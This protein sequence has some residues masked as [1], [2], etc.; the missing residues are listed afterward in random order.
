MGPNQ[1]QREE[2]KRRIIVGFN[3]RGRDV[4][5]V[6][7]EIQQK[8][9]QQIKFP[10]GY[11]PT[12]GGQF[13]N[14]QEANA[15]LSIAIPAALALIFILL[16]LT[17]QSVKQSLV[18]FTAIPMAAIGGVFSLL[19]RGMPFSISAGIGFI[20]L[21]GVAV[22]NG[23]VL[24]AEFNRLK[25]AGLTDLYDIVRKG[26]HIRLR[27]VLMTAA[28]ASLGFMPMALATS[29][30]A[31]VQKPLAT[32]VIGGLISSTLLTLIVIP[33][34]Y[35]YSEKI[36]LR[37]IKP[38]SMVLV[39]FFLLLG[40]SS[41]QA[42]EQ[43]QVV[44]LQ[45]AIEIALKNNEGIKAVTYEVES[46]KQLKKT[47]L[48]LPKTDITFMRGQY[49]SYYKNDNNITVM[50]SIPFTSLGSNGVLNR[51]LVESSELKKASTENE[52]IYQVKQT[53]YQ[54]AYANARHELLLQ[55]DSIYEGFFKAASLRYKAGETN[56]LEQ[57]T[58]EAQRN[59]IKNQI[60]QNEATQFIL[61]TQLKMLM[62]S[63]VL[64]EI[65]EE[66][67]K[68][69]DLSNSLDTTAL[70]SNPSLA[71]MRQQVEVTKSEKKVEASKFA[72]DLLVGFFS[73]TLIGAVNTETGEVASSSDRF[74]GFQ[75][76]V[77]VPLWFVP[78]QGRVKAASLQQ[79]AAQSEYQNF[80][81]ALKGQMQQALQQYAKNKSSLEYYRT[82]ALPNSNL[83]LKHSQTAFR[84]GEIG[85][86]EYLL[87]VRNA[88]SIRENFLQTLKEY[89]QSVIYIEFLSGNK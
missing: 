66:P 82:S 73:Q 77:S 14:L 36:D 89:N 29:A 33:C 48:D 3:V 19:V 17:F 68:E 88:V 80:Q 32:V 9:E 6:V 84:G 51:S 23:I 86:T 8:I 50:Q 74:T 57:T 5:S 53:Y 43:K 87:G 25:K 76:G 64:P 78:H 34:I 38:T 39:L 42:Q 21:F 54:L 22:L 72:P 65:S 59:E 52:L 49:N 81:V 79:Q 2:A 44:D 60:R 26:T 46:K 71:F 13:E 83:I 37:K 4:A 62:N 10:P 47:S 7:K 20:A 15:R 35:I 12:Y 61:R 69:I 11:Y 41:I 75:I 70:A 85:Y 63:D 18:I 27:P 31:E 55:Q 30:G 40:V 24:I 16:Y 45:Q 28:V 67:F 1:I 56:L 58:A